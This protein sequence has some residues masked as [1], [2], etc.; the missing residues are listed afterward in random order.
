MSKG[1]SVVIIEDDRFLAD[2]YR[3]VLERVGGTVRMAHDPRTAM[4]LIDQ[5]VPEVIIADMLLPSSTVL[6]LLHELQSYDDTKRVPVV[7]VTNLAHTLRLE[8]MK[9]Y[10]V[11][12]LLDKTTMEPADIAAAV[13]GA[14]TL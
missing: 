7:L 9:Q 3:V 12:K 6:P 13:R 8:D 2:Y 11:V 1:P 10:G 4:E 5:A 14:S